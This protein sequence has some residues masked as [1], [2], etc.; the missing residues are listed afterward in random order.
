M[1]ATISRR[2]IMVL[3]GTAVAAA[4]V[5]AALVLVEGDPETLAG[6]LVKALADP[7]GAAGIG[8]RWMK[9]SGYEPAPAALAGKIAKRLRAHGWRPGDTPERLRAALA[10]RLREEFGQDALVDVAGWRMARTGAELCAL[11][12]MHNAESLAPTHPAEG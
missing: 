6:E 7:V 9:A 12:A 5:P 10:A 8:R 4:A 11:A 2:N 1:A 3:A